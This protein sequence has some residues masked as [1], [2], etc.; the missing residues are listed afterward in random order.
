MHLYVCIDIYALYIYMYA[1]C[2]T[3]DS[4]K[5]YT[6]IAIFNRLIRNSSKNKIKEKNLSRAF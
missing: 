2:D 5:Y 3:R 1:Q 4:I 6:N